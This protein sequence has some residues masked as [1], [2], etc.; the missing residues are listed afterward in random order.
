MRGQTFLADALNEP[1]PLFGQDTGP[2]MTVREREA[3]HQV[4]PLF[5]IDVIEAI[6]EAGLAMGALFGFGAGAG[7]GVQTF[8]EEGTGRFDDSTATEIGGPVLFK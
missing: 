5:G 4:L 8:G 3:I 1:A 2:S 6:E 7:I